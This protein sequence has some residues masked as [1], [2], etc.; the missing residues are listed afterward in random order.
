MDILSSTDE[1]MEEVILK[2]SSNGKKLSMVV[3]KNLFQVV[4]FHKKSILIAPLDGIEVSLLETDSSF[5]NTE[6]LLGQQKSIDEVNLKI[7][8]KEE[9]DYPAVA[10]G[11]NDLKNDGINSGEYIVA[12]YGIDNFDFTLG[13]IV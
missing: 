11:F 13:M 6:M 3:G 4:R 10:V 5:Y 9:G 1:N 12:S 7:R 8:L 2:Q